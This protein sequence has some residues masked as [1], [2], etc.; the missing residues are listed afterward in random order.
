MQRIGRDEAYT[1]VIADFTPL[2]GRLI[3]LEGKFANFIA[4]VAVTLNIVELGMI[5]DST[6]CEEGVF[7]S[8]NPFTN[9]VVDLA[10][11]TTY[12]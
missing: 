5:I 2:E 10:T 11:G 7:T 9:M 1:P 4:A 8:P 3:G 12:T 6:I